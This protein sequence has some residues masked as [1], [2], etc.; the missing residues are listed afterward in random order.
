MIAFFLWFGVG[1]TLQ[2]QSSAFEAGLLAYDRG[3]YAA[4][5]SAWSAMP[6]P[7]GEVWFNLGKAYLELGDRGRSLLALRR[8]A[9]QL[10]RDADVN[11]LLV[12]LR[13][14]TQ[15]TT[16]P[17]DPLFMLSQITGGMLTLN[18]LAWLSFGLWCGLFGMMA[19]TR[20]FSAQA[21]LGRLFANGLA[22]TQVILVGLLLSRIM[23]EALYPAA[24]VI[25]PSAQAY[26]GAGADYLPIMRV[27]NATEVRVIA[28]EGDWVRVILAD[29]HQG[30][31]ER[32]AIDTVRGQ[33]PPP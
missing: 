19:L 7:S 14:Q 9:E 27:P 10:P 21:D 16:E 17:S 4:A 2:A 13:V 8:A 23:I 31:L 30:W 5:I 32:S 11:L 3:D 12:Q 29:G 25:V 18:E 20:W 26:T 24:V 15:T 1:S 33:T 6:N 22:V 28:S